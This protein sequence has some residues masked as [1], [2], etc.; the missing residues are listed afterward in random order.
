MFFQIT[1][2]VHRP[3]FSAFLARVKYISEVCMFLMNHTATLCW[4]CCGHL[5]ITQ[6]VSEGRGI[7]P[8]KQSTSRLSV[9][10]GHT[11]NES[12]VTG[13]CALCWVCTHTQIKTHWTR[14][15]KWR[16][17][18]GEE[19]AIFP[20]GMVY[21]K[22]G[23]REK[24]RESSFDVDFVLW[25]VLPLQRRAKLPAIQQNNKKVKAERKRDRGGCS[26]GIGGVRRQS[27]KKG[28]SVSS[29]VKGPL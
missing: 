14:A 13:L 22:E 25:T 16:V 2:H 6:R 9:D 20:E 24:F 5:E 11:V 23:D 17:N 21:R 29:V 15:G 12:D 26:G 7:R 19:K 1:K 4:H 28:A 27:G 8:F 10:R 3:N 18:E